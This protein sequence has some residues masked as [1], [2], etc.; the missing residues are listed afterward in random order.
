MLGS[1]H[2]YMPVEGK[3]ISM[4]QNQTFNLTWKDFLLL[5]LGISTLGLLL[6]NYE[7]VDGLAEHP[8]ATLTFGKIDSYSLIN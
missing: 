1:K 6:H 2:Q 8:E 4:K 7:L 3:L 5:V